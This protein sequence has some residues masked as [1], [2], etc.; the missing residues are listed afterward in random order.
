MSPQRLSWRC[1]RTLRG[2][3]L[4]ITFYGNFNLIQVL[5]ILQNRKVL[6][7]IIP[8]LHAGELF[9]VADVAPHLEQIIR[10]YMGSMESLKLVGIKMKMENLHKWLGVMRDSLKSLYMEKIKLTGG[11]TFELIMEKHCPNLMSLTANLVENMTFR[12]AEAPAAAVEPLSIDIEWH[13][14]ANLI[15][16]LSRK[17]NEHVILGL[18]KNYACKYNTAWKAFGSVRHIKELT[19][20]NRFLVHRQ[21]GKKRVVVD[22][23]YYDFHDKPYDFDSVYCKCCERV[24]DEDKAPKCLLYLTGKRLLRLTVDIFEEEMAKNF[25]ALYFGKLQELNVTQ[26]Y[27][28]LMNAKELEG[29]CSLTQLKKLSITTLALKL[30]GNDVLSIVES[31]DNLVELHLAKFKMPQGFKQSLNVL[32]KSHGRKLQLIYTAIKKSP[33][34]NQKLDSDY[35]LPEVEGDEYKF[36]FQ[37]I[38]V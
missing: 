9:A 36:L 29:L 12:V 23:D 21:F 8:Y 1:T 32:L 38:P 24:H 30:S 25:N 2:S 14:P 11:G 19:I 20:R 7:L 13:R 28:A 35:N 17:T 6:P 31:L 5:F 4:L 34:V 15:S 3:V 27:K 26:Y 33:G 10:P 37:T 16:V 18:H 22:E